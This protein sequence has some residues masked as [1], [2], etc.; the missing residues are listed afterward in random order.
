[1]EKKELIEVTI[2]ET[3][4]K[5]L[6]EVAMRY[7]CDMGLLVDAAIKEKLKEDY[8]EIEEDFEKQ[9]KMCGNCESWKSEDADYGYLPPH[10]CQNEQ[11]PCFGQD[12]VFSD[13]CKHQRQKKGDRK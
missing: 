2:S 11:S 8:E 6:A 13:T 7:M 10:R 1:M 3:A 5:M 9:E 4:Y 12:T